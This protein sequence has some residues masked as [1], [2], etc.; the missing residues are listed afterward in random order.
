MFPPFLPMPHPRRLPT[1]TAVDVYFFN[2][3][4]PEGRKTAMAGATIFTS[5]VF[6][7]IQRGI[8][9]VLL[10]YLYLQL[11]EIQTWTLLLPVAIRSSDFSISFI[12]DKSLPLTSIFPSHRTIFDE[13]HNFSLISRTYRV[14]FLTV[15]P[16]FITKMKT[17]GNQPEILFHEILDVQKILVG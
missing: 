1:P 13:N 5:Q 17:M 2:R 16:I 7:Q 3:K 15:L 10:I 9:V 14:V 4:K 12:W 11:L 8:Y 6:L